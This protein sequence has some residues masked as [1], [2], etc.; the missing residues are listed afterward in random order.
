MIYGP[1]ALH[2]GHKSQTENSA[3]IK[4]VYVIINIFNNIYIYIY[5]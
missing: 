1:H 5:I 2:L 4:E 3:N